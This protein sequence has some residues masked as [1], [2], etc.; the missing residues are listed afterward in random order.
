M[1][2]SKGNKGIACD[3]NNL[4]KIRDGEPLDGKSRAEDDFEEEDIIM[5]EIL[6]VTIWILI[7]G[8]VS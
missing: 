2:N 4:Q 6:S 3:L 7:G 5:M 1:F 8:N